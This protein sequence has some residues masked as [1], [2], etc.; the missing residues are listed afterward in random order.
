MSPSSGWVR[1]IEHTADV[2]IEA[3][4]ADLPG[5][6]DRCAAGMTELIAEGAP[7]E[8]RVEHPVTASG[9]DLAELLADFLRQLLWLHASTGFLYAGARFLQL[10]PTALDAVVAGEPADPDRHALVREIK[11]VTYHQLAVTPSPEGWRAQV[12]FDV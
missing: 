3:G 8:P 1:P 7:P 4:A 10:E 6:F 9:A 12:I 11:A 2:A 5:L